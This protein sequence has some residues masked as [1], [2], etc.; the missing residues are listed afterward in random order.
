MKKPIVIVNFKSY[1]EATGASG[2]QLAKA[3]ERVAK[4]THL[5]IAVAV[6]PTDI[7]MIS[8]QVNIPVYAEH[9]DPFPAN[10][11]TGFITPEAVKSSGASGTLLNHSEHRVRIDL[12]EQSIVRAKELGLKTVVC[13]NDPLMVVSVSTFKPDIVAYEPPELIAGNVSVS[14]AK[15]DAIKKTIRNLR[16]FGMNIPLLVGAG[17]KKNEDVVL[18]LDYGAD[19]ILIASGIVKAKDPE[20]ALLDL[21]KGFY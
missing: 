14:Q 13:A 8:H 1:I 11:N 18:A 17:V 6:Q 21:L 12:L 2:L 3:I 4:Y 10:R 9:I 20:Q 19:G 7:F 15:P 5:D 16:A